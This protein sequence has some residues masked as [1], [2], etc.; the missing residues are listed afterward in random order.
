MAYAVI[1]IYYLQTFAFTIDIDRD[2][3]IKY[4]TTVPT[5][6]NTAFLVKISE[7]S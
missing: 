2:Y 7:I 5:F 1:T 6:G 4:L 3:Y